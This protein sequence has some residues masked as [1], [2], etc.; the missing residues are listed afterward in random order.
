MPCAFYHPKSDR[1]STSTTKLAFFSTKIDHYIIPDFSTRFIYKNHAC[2]TRLGPNFIAVQDLYLE[3][4]HFRLSLDVAQS[5]YK[6][7]KFHLKL[8]INDPNKAT[9]NMHTLLQ[10]SAIYQLL[11]PKVS[12]VMILDASGVVSNPIA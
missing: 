11:S 2:R 7:N 6:A 5:P 4:R 12:L 9:F 10:S 1:L 8:L 3:Y